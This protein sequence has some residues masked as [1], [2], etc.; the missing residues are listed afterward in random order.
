MGYE[1][2][3]HR[4]SLPYVEGNGDIW[5]CDEC[6]LLWRSYAPGNPAYNA[7]RHVGWLGRWMLEGRRV[8]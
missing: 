4:C 8:A 7:W 1:L 6:D 5:R 3:Q 2:Q